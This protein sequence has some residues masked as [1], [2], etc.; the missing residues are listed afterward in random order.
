MHK[1]TKIARKTF[2]NFKKAPIITTK[3]QCTELRTKN[4]KKF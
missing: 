1:T 3:E 2:Q 4:E